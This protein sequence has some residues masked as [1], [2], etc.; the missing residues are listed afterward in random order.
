MLHQL[1]IT[2]PIKVKVK[3][4][5]DT[6]KEDTTKA[7]KEEVMTNITMNIDAKEVMITM[8]MVKETMATI[9]ETIIAVLP[10]VVLV[11]ELVQPVC[12]AA[13]VYDYLQLLL[14]YITSD[15]DK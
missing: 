5:V 13:V 3:V 7:I 6:I 11:V 2:I 15:I 12:S 4:K 8:D 14:Q 1:I 9:K 10:I